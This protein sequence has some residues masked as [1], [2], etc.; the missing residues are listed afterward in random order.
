LKFQEER[1]SQKQ[2]E[3]RKVNYMLTK[4]VDK[5]SAKMKKRSSRIVMSNEAR[6]LKDMRIEAGLSMR[7]AG[8]LVDR[9]DSYIAHIETGRIDPPVGDKL[10]RLLDVYSG[11]KVKSFYE[12][13]REYKKRITP[14]EELR[15]IVE[16]VST[17]NIISL[18][19]VAKS[20]LG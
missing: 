13:C 9:S 16:R 1:Q 15:E 19:N 6:V 2:F 18:L 11:I 4:Y 5:K 3:W 14:R 20:L 8:A 17:E 7:K 12:R 10:Q